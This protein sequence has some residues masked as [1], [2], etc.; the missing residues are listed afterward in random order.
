MEF[1]RMVAADTGI[2]AR[3]GTSMLDSDREASLNLG[4]RFI[5]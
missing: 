5:R 4:V 3:I 2:W 1:G